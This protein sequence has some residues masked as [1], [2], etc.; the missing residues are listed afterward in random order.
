MKWGAQAP[1]G[2]CVQTLPRQP[3]AASERAASQ[4]LRPGPRMEPGPHQRRGQGC[5]Q[6]RPRSR[7]AGRP[8]CSPLVCAHELLGLSPPSRGSS[9]LMPVVSPPSASL[10]L[11]VGIGRGTYRNNRNPG[12]A[13]GVHETLA[14]VFLP[15]AALVT[16]QAEE[17][18]ITPCPLW[19]HD[20]A[21]AQ[22]GHV[23]GRQK[24]AQAC[25]ARRVPP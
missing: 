23:E 11:A 24:R 16:G 3:R 9:G 1:V 14:S 20:P 21:E 5:T 18:P 6:P 4:G 13:G 25:S 12:P 2:G 17:S 8:L 10:L 7:Q 22:T 19:T 15:Q